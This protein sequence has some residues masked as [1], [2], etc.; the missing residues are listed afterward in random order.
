M[1][2]VDALPTA[3]ACLNATCFLFLVGGFVAIKK[4]DRHRHR[5]LMLW[6]VAFAALFL[7][8]YLTRVALTG[9]T[10][11]PGTGWRKGLYLFILFTHM[12]LAAIVVPMCLRALWL[13]WKR[14]F[15]DHRRLTRWL[16]PI[17]S[18]V[19]VTGVLVYFMLHHW[20]GA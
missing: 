7:V 1:T 9:T 13:A 14:R 4:G 3:I 5:K 17:W 8:V 6:A 2:V 11:F 16:W 18:Y 20:H 10:Y 15:A 19:S 12:P